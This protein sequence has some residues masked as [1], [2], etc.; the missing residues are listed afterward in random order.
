MRPILT[1]LAEA[2]A[3]AVLAALVSDV[4]MGAYVALH[5]RL[6]GDTPVNYATAGL[7]SVGIASAATHLL[8]E[9]V[10]GNRMWC[11]AVLGIP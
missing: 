11:K 9:A 2:A 6:R 1:V 3:A 4:V 7:A 5:A 8:L 10:G